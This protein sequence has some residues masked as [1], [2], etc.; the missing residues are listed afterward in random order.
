MRRRKRG[1]QPEQGRSA[2]LTSHLL[3]SVF[4]QPFDHVAADIACFAGGQIAVIALLKVDTQLAGD[5][6]LPIVQRVLCLRYIDLV[7]V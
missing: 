4:D 1:A 5:F 6:L 2:V 7:A 3:L